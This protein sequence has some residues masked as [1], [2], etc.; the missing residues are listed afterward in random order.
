M[1]KESN[2]DHD[3]RVSTCTPQKT[4]IQTWPSRALDYKQV[5]EKTSFGNTV[6]EMQNNVK[7]GTS[8]SLK[9]DRVLDDNN[10]FANN[11][12]STQRQ[13]NP[14]SIATSL[15]HQSGHTGMKINCSNKETI[16]A[17][18]STCPRTA[19]FDHEISAIP[20]QN[21]LT[22][23]ILLYYVSYFNLQMTALKESKRHDL[24]NLQ[25]VYA[26]LLPN[27]ILFLI[28]RFVSC[29]NDWIP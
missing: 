6:N 8:Y 4:D 1:D 28:I 9:G 29:L 19:S 13:K 21:S 23:V 10:Q 27:Y 25:Y 7:M 11:H 14:F 24:L 26:D 20:G 12:A 5:V 15:E 2:I 22:Q 16:S 18:H 3:P 17:T